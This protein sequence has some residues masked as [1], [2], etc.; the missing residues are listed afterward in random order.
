MFIHFRGLEKRYQN[1][2]ASKWF[3]VFRILEIW[4][5]IERCRLKIW[6]SL[7]SKMEKYRSKLKFV[8]SA[9]ILNYSL[10]L[11]IK[12]IFRIL[13]VYYNTK[14]YAKIV[15]FLCH[16]MCLF[17]CLLLKIVFPQHNSCLKGFP[18]RFKWDSSLKLFLRTWHREGFSPIFQ[19]CITLM[20]HCR[21]L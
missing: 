15:I 16:C 11:L 21:A 6:E 4:T 9:M 19:I 1:R 17:F 14:L 10:G 7:T 2:K 8:I 12:T 3:N 5:K 13:R 18:C 20:W